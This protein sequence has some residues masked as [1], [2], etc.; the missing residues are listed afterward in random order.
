MSEIRSV[1][2]LGEQSMQQRAG[3]RA[4]M[5]ARGAQLIR[6]MLP[7]QHRDFFAQLPLLFVGSIDATGQPWASVLAGPPGFVASPD[8]QLLSVTTMLSEADPLRTTLRDEA[9]LGLLGLEPHTRRRNRANGTVIQHSPTGFS[10]RVKE[11]FGNCPKYIHAREPT[12]R[13]ND[14]APVSKAVLRL[15]Q[16]DFSMQQMVARADTFFIASAF[17]EAGTADAHSTSVD[18]SHRGGK[19]G[20]VRIDSPTQLTVPDFVGNNFFNT[21]GNLL[22]HPRAG[23]L[24]VD[25][26]RGD[27][28]Y[29]AAQAQ[30]IETGSDLDAFAGARRLLQFQITQAVLARAALPIAWGAASLS[31][32]LAAT[33]SW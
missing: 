18:V 2:H 16:L 12:W 6:P 30:V 4:Q 28:L 25:Y 21:L 1:F 14:G 33:G 20:F 17:V 5:E 9:P 19:P 11:S 8:P 31:P 7:Q 10:L 29:V 26:E 24:F 13:G 3:V 23:L 15:N 32:V 27:L 22:Q